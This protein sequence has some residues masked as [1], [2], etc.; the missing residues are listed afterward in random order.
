V[1]M[2]YS[3]ISSINNHFILSLL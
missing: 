2:E 1:A 3:F